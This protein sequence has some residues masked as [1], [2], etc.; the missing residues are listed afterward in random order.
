MN[1]VIRKS[2]RIALFGTASL[3]FTLLAITA[4]ASDSAR[5]GAGGIDRSQSAAVTCYRSVTDP[6]SI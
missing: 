2:R 5:V 1:T 4:S 6:A 3:A